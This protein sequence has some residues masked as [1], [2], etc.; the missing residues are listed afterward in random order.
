MRVIQN[1]LDMFRTMSAS[2]VALTLS[3]WALSIPLVAFGLKKIINL[4]RKVY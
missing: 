3:S 1:Y 4:I 2:V